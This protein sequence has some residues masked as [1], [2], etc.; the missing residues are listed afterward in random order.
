[1]KSL[2]VGT[3]AL[4][5]ALFLIFTLV[6]LLGEPFQPS[7]FIC[8]VIGSYSIGSP[9]AWYCFRQNDR[10]KATL[11]QLGEAHAELTEIARRDGMTGLL[12]RE[13]FIREAGARQGG[14]LL[15]VD[16]DRFKSINDSFGH[17]A[18][19]AALL[20]VVSAI[21]ACIGESDFSGRIGGEEFA[22]FLPGAD[23]QRAGIV[24]AAIRDAVRAIEFRPRG[25]VAHPLTVSIGAS[26]LGER[27]DVSSAMLAA[28]RQLYAAKNAGRDRL[29]FAPVEARAA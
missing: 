27:E 28:D 5:F 9:V 15:L 1:V 22:S 11:R 2:G 14:W 7:M 10:L 19:D 21:R 17:A 26:A 12:N 29:R 23:R 18:G 3:G 4:A 8:A 13:A 16:I 20:A 6:P 25:D 24:A